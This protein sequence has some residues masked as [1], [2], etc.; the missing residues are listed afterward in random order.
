MPKMEVEF[1]FLVEIDTEEIDDEFIKKH[2]GVVK[3]IGAMLND[4]VGK[5]SRVAIVNIIK[6]E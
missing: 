3:E 4:R 5:V 6:D 1:R 2:A